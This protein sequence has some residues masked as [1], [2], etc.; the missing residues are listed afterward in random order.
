MLKSGGMEYRC[1]DLPQYGVVLVSPLSAEYPALL[2]DI[3]HRVS[4][5]VLGSPPPL[6]GGEDPAAPTMV[7][8]NRSQTAIAAVSWIWKFEPET[9]RPTTHSVAI[10]GGTSLLAPFGLDD[11]V[12]RLY[13]YWRVILPG[14]KRAI[15]GSRMLGDNTDVRPPQ[16]DEV[17]KGGGFGV[18][19]GSPNP[20]G[21]LKSVALT[22]DGIFFL[23]GRFAGPDTLGNFDRVTA[24]VDAHRQVGKIAREGHNNGLSPTAIF[25][26]IETLTGPIQVGPPPH[27][28]PPLPP[29]KGRSY[30]DYR[31]DSL[32]SIASQVA[33]MRQ[34]GPGDEQTIYRL[35]EWTE[36]VLPKFEKL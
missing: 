29:G 7:L 28:P 23:D 10:G 36:T 17:W 11:R 31:Q 9:G 1:E 19:S 2:A 14:S 35:M 18:G 34:Y 3:E 20:P 24:D 5:P 6:P 33:S 8:W 26:Q 12:R 25:A 16:P 15:R 32:R 27:V 13:G 30:S 21:L 4:N 22:L